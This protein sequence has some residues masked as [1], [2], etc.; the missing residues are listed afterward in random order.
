[1]VQLSEFLFWFIL[2]YHYYH[3]TM[4]L[5][6]S[7]NSLVLQR[8]PRRL[9]PI[10][11]ANLRS[12]LTIP[13]DVEVQTKRERTPMRRLALALSAVLS[14][15]AAPVHAQASGASQLQTV[16][17]GAGQASQITLAGSVR[18]VVLG[19]PLVADVSVI[20]EH[21]LVVLG[22]RPGMTSLMAFDVQGRALADRRIVVSETPDD[23]VT[24]QRGVM[25]SSYACSARC[26]K[27]SGADSAAPAPTTP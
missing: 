19:D 17:L 9:D 22:K 4:R 7:K 16:S 1:M 5:G 27:L 14:L 2:I 3:L 10:T 8:I 12:L 21:T 11:K 15:H 18:D 25:A 6:I 24:V 13:G 23:A 20:N 26:S